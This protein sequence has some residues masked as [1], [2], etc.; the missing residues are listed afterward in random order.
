MR[1]LFVLLLLPSLLGAVPARGEIIERI[2]AKVNGD[3]ITLSDFQERQLT[4]AQ[5][6][7]VDP[8]FGP[9]QIN[10]SGC[11]LPGNVK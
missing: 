10:R 3:I 6:A 8:T 2:I 7:R 1:R 9:I 5:V 4:A 11:R